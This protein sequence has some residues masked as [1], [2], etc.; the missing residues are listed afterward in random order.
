MDFSLLGFQQTKFLVYIGY[1][2]WGT[3]VSGNV[4]LLSALVAT[5]ELLPGWGCTGFTRITMKF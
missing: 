5:P 1:I 3:V 4:A 2:V